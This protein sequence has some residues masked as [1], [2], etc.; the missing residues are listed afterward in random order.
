MSTIEKAAAR[1][2]ALENQHKDVKSPGDEEGPVNSGSTGASRHLDSTL[3]AKTRMQVCEFDMAAVAERGFLVPGDTRSQ[4]AREMR[5]IKRPLLLN[6]KKSLARSETTRNSNLIMVTSAFPGEGKT[7]VSIN[8][9]MSLAAEVDKRVLLVDGDV[10]KGD[11]S[12]QLGVEPTYGLADLLAEKD[13]N[14]ED[15]IVDTNVERLNLLL[16]GRTHDHIDEMYASELMGDL[17]RQLSEQDPD[18]VVIF[19][20]PPVL[21]TTEAL[22]LAQH[23]GQIIVVVEADR[24]PH[25]AVQEVTTLLEDYPNV[26]LLLN[27]SRTRD[28]KSYN[29]GYGSYGYGYGDHAEEEKPKGL[30]NRFKRKAKAKP[31]NAEP[32]VDKIVEELETTG[33]HGA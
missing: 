22:V 28:S 31:A 24:T 5:R 1:L 33:S 9:A 29:Y 27:K 3:F 20:A 8:L 14:V 32:P 11:I 16:A 2:A 18:R 17:T 30:R 26:S 15:A 7:F 4:L 23:M 21:A 6:I 12:R 10:P 19:D 13:A 25:A